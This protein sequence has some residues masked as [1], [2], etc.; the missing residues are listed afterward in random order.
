MEKKC[1]LYTSE[2]ISRFVDHELSFDQYRSCERHLLL[3]RDCSRLVD[4]YKAVSLAFSRHAHGEKIGA[5]TPDFKHSLDK[6]LKRS[7]NNS[8]Q[9][10]SGLFGKNIYLKLAGIAAVLMIGLFPFDGD[11]FQ[12]PAG[13]SAIVNSVDAEDA[14]VMIIETKNEKHTIIWFSEET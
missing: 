7:E 13:P 9:N 5:H 8:L 12:N 4:R 2:D 11:L 3:C 6:A 14:S 10:I 1:D